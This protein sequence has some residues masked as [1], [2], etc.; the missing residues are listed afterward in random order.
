MSDSQLGR[1]TQRLMEIETYRLMSLLSLPLARE[2]TP[3]LNDMD[4]QLAVITSP[5][6]TQ[7]IDEREVLADLT[8]IAARIEAFRAHAPF[9]SRRHGPITSWC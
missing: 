6:R 3:S 9:A 4:Q 2:M 1:L 8:N 7:D 5:W